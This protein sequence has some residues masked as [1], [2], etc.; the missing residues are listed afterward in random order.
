MSLSSPE[1]GSFLFAF[2]VLLAGVTLLG[3][4]FEKLRQP[5][6]AGE[7]LAG[8][9]LGP[10]I[11]GALAPDA[12]RGLFGSTDVSGKSSIIFGALY[13]IGLLLLMFLS[14]T[15]M[16][17]L[18]VKGMRREIGWLCGVGTLVPFLLILLFGSFLPMDAIAQGS[19]P[20]LAALIVLAIAVAVTSIPVIARIFH[21]LGILQTRFAGLILGAAALDD[22]ILWGVLAIATAL[23]QAQGVMSGHFFGAM[24]RDVS[25][26]LGF[27][28]IGFFLAPALLRK[29]NRARI[30]TLARTSPLGYAVLVLLAYTTLATWLKVDLVFAAF[31]AGYGLVAGGEPAVAGESASADESAPRFEHVLGES[32]QSVKKVAFTVFIPVYFGLIGQKLVFGGEFSLGLLLVFLVGSSL[33]RMLAA[34]AASHLAGFRGL[35]PFNI[36]IALNARGGPGIVLASV[37]YE[38]HIINASFYTVLVLTAL[39][40]S[41]AAGAWLMFVLRKGWPLLSEK[42][43]LKDAP[44]VVPERVAA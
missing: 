41:Q 6:L 20:R 3:S 28:G 32:L 7:I 37:A 42:S 9:L 12:Y 11:F 44:V 21:D 16:K 19:T 5:K 4:L 18:F 40:T 25:V 13:W 38:A 15:E 8:I 10:F 29:L 43:P 22:V 23:A 30:N 35:D 17:R 24:A 27:M 36:S 26:T 14:G 34:G 39:F 31:L 1:L 33:L 2:A